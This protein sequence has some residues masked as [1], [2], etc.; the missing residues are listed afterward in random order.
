MVRGWGLIV[1]Y[2]GTVLFPFFF[3]LSMQYSCIRGPMKWRKKLIQGICHLEYTDACIY[4]IAND[5]PQVI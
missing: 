1:A 2:I 4:H 3:N 5:N